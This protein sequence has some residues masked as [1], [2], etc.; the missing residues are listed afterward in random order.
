MRNLKITAYFEERH[1]NTPE[2]STFFGH[3]SL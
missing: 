2:T 3:R 1:I